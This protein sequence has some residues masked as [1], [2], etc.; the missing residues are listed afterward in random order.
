MLDEL[1]LPR[2]EGHVDSP[3]GPPHEDGELEHSGVVYLFGPDDRA[4]VLHSGG[5]TVAQ[6]TSDLRRLLSE[7]S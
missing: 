7:G 4:T 6:Y 3:G 2:T 5:T 1:H